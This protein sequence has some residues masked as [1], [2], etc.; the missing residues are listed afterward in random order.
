MQSRTEYLAYID[1]GQV[2][3]DHPQVTGQDLVDRAGGQQL[4][5]MLE[6]GSQRSVEPTDTFDLSEAKHF[7]RPPRFKRG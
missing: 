6:D 7:K 4:V 5:E 3:F 2:E 1:D